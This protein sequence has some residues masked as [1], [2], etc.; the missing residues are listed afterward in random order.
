MSTTKRLTKAERRSRRIR[1]T[2]CI[3]AVAVLL[4]AA[5]IFF[6]QKKV[7]QDFASNGQDV[8][9][10]QVSVGSI[11][12]TVSGSGSLVS[13]GV[14]EV[15]LPD[16]VSIKKLYVEEGSA[17]EE[18]QLLASLDSA[19]VLSALSSVQGELDALDKLDNIAALHT[20]HLFTSHIGE[21]VMSID[22]FQFP[23]AVQ[24]GIGR[25]EL[26]SKIA[27]LLFFPVYFA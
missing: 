13:D 25:T 8:S 9:T 16:G 3:V 27:N 11:S 26:I 7:R 10:A 23:E 21:R 22:L 19:S 5:G 2:I 15:T 12:T 14:T 4:I 18:G 1:I 24:L 17:V 6:L 20:P